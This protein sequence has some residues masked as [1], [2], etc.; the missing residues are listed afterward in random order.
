VDAYAV[1]LTVAPGTYR[2]IGVLMKRDLNRS[3]VAAPDFQVE[4][5]TNNAFNLPGA[6]VAHWQVNVDPRVAA[7]E[8]E[9]FEDGW[10][11]G[12][13]FWL[14]LSIP[15]Y[16]TWTAGVPL[17]GTYWAVV[18]NNAAGNVRVAWGVDQDA[19]NNTRC[20]SLN[21][22]N[23]TAAL[24]N[25]PYLKLI[26]MDY[27]D[28][29]V[30]AFLDFRGNDLIRRTYAAVGPRVMY[31]DD[32]TA[33]W[34]ESK[35]N[36]AG[37]VTDLIEWKGHLFAAQGDAG[38]MYYS[39]GEAGDGAL[40]HFHTADNDD[41]VQFPGILT[42]GGSG[43]TEPPGVEIEPPN[44]GVTGTQAVA[45]VKGG[46]ADFDPV[47]GEVLAVTGVATCATPEGDRYDGFGGD[48]V[49]A[50]ISRWHAVHAGSCHRQPVSAYCFAV[51]NS[52]FFWALGNT[53]Y[54]S[55][56]DMTGM[57]TWDT[58]EVGDSGTPITAMISHDG[59]LYVAKPEGIYQIVYDNSWPGAG[60]CGAHLVHDFSTD[61]AGRP[62]LLDWQSGLYWPS[63]G[64][65]YEWKSGVLQNIWQEFIDDEADVWP[66][67]DPARPG[68]WIGAHGT[69]RGMLLARGGYTNAL[70]QW[71]WYDHGQW[72]PI[73][74]RAVYCEPMGPP[75]ISSHGAGRGY[76]YLAHGY[77]IVRLYWPLWTD[78][79]YLDPDS[80]FVWCNSEVT[81]PEMV[82]SRPDLL[83]DWV[84]VQLYSEDLGN[85]AGQGGTVVLDY[86]LDGGPWLTLGPPAGTGWLATFEESPVARVAFPAGTYSYRI[87]LLLKL[88]PRDPT[89]PGTWPPGVG[90]ADTTTTQK[91]REL[92]LFYHSLPET[93]R[94]WQYVIDSR[95]EIYRRTGGFD[96]RRPEDIN[97]EILAL[98]E[99][100]EPVRLVDTEGATHYVRVVGATIADTRWVEGT[101]TTGIEQQDQVVV[102][103]LAMPD[104]AAGV[105]GAPAIWGLSE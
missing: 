92:T 74:T 97:A 72:V 91:L 85:A 82:G 104:T 38:P 69:T 46:P 90:E 88:I 29:E 5:W 32:A 13:Y 70:G 57:A 77:G 10:L 18:R 19:A 27:P 6:M 93:V 59:Y 84:E 39:P 64:G 68:F 83:K 34:R 67:A 51:H 94:Q 24:A 75:W 12:Q 96:Q 2:N 76:A 101:G 20:A 25:R 21:G 26:S 62:F 14:N 86:S 95:K 41:P 31:Y 4:I 9:P 78:S 17:N 16:D 50:R 87:D 54:A 58:C 3:Y 80:T 60:E 47:A 65:V 56:G 99:S 53:L 37:K 36:F 7:D 48:V 103:L 66:D 61:R 35:G 15:L 45:E 22:V 33:G 73:M 102:T 81:L 52:C 63:S 100:S 40:V 105:T 23:W 89:V 28:R 49:E 43:Y 30:A 42:D 79:A 8:W 55:Y 98:L 11:N 44:I 71:W 1:Q